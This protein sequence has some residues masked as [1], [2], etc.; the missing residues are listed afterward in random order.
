MKLLLDQNI[1]F[2]LLRDLAPLFPESNHVRLLGFEHEND[3]LIWDYAQ[4]NNFAIVTQ[5]SDFYDRSIIYGHPPKIIWI[6]SGNISTSYIRN[7][8]IQKAKL[9]IEFEKDPEVSCLE[10]Y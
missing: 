10:L 7:M 2:K 4:E 8:L 9:I 1:S 5:D 6:K 3:E